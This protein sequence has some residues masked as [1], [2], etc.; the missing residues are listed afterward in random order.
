MA[1]I[2][3]AEYDLG[4]RKPVTQIFVST[5]LQCAVPMPDKNC[6]LSEIIENRITNYQFHFQQLLPRFVYINLQI[7]PKRINH[8]RTSNDI[9]SVIQ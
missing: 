4:L 2:P 8:Y 3:A 1:A 6:T 5:V 9:A 7:L